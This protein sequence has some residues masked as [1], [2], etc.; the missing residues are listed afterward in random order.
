V[1]LFKTY[2]SLT[3]PTSSLLPTSSIVL[4]PRNPT[5]NDFGRQ[6]YAT[7]K[8]K[9]AD[10]SC[11]ALDGYVVAIDEK[12]DPVLRSSFDIWLTGLKAGTSGE[13]FEAGPFMKQFLTLLADDAAYRELAE[14]SSTYEIRMAVLH[15]INDINL[16]RVFNLVQRD[17]LDRVIADDT[18]TL[19]VMRSSSAYRAFAKGAR[20]LAEK[21]PPRIEDS[22]LDISVDV[23]L[24]GFEAPHVAN[25]KFEGQPRLVSD[26]VQVLIGKNGTGKSQLLNQLVGSLALQADQSESDAFIDKSNASF[27]QAAA[28]WKAIPNSVLVFSTDTEDVFPRK[29][30]LDAPL[31]YW[32]FS[33]ASQGSDE[34]TLEMGSLPLGRAL[35]P[36]FASI[37]YS[38]AAQK[39]ES[40]GQRRCTR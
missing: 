9:G 3:E 38:L 21:V 32:Y 24:K 35:R 23:L 39:P 22:R 28:E 31:D 20:Y 19:G 17:L 15:A 7:I 33:L 34:P 29:A 4:S 40:N 11:I 12:A 2:F 26:R 37:A 25:F 30:R 16:A 18:F 5:W 8:I 36:D 13:L 14:W 27:N 10:S 6:V 1:G